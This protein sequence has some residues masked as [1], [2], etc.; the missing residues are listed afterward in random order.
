MIFT[1]PPGRKVG[2]APEDD[3]VFWN[4]FSNPDDERDLA[5][6]EDRFID[7]SAAWVEHHRLAA[8]EAAA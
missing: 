2:Y 8:L 1:A 3:V 5:V 4:V 7:K 6:L